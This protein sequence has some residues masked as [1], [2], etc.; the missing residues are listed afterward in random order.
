MNLVGFD[1]ETIELIHKVI[2]IF[3]NFQF[4]D[5]AE[6]WKWLT[7]KG[8]CFNMPEYFFYV[9]PLCKKYNKCFFNVQVIRG[10][11]NLPYK[12]GIVFTWNPDED[13]YD[14]MPYHN[15]MD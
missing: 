5:D 4:A 9:L 12:F 11:P 1:E 7:I 3:I 2:G 13:R 14:P 10:D 15:P 6:N 8:E